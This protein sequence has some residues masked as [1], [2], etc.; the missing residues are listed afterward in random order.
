MKTIA[1]FSI[2]FLLLLTAIVAGFFSGV[3]TGERRGEQAVLQRH[4]QAELFV[5]IRQEFPG[6]RECLFVE[7]LRL[8]DRRVDSVGGPGTGQLD[9]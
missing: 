5:A 6:Q 2:S 1:R 7:T 8:P 9:R 3:R 4:N